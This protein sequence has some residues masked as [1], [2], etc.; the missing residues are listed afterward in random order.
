MKNLK[1][2]TLPKLKASLNANSLVHT[3]KIARSNLQKLKE[4]L[5]DREG[6]AQSRYKFKN[7]QFESTKATK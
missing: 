5:K 2:K 6:P 4:Y 1:K 7:T 3:K